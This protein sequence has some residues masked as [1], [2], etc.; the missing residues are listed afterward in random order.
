MFRFQDCNSLHLKTQSNGFADRTSCLA[1]N[2]SAKEQAMRY[3]LFLFFF[4]CIASLL[5]VAWHPVAC[6]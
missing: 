6:V 3:A 5:C 4:F 2:V 1:L